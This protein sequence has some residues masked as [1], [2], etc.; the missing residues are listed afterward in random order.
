M[1][2]PTASTH[3]I[4]MQMGRDT[5]LGSIEEGNGGG[6][7]QGWKMVG[8]GYSVGGGSEGGGVGPESQQQPTTKASPTAADTHPPLLLLELLQCWN[9]LRGRESHSGQQGATDLGFR[10]TSNSPAS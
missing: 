7:G 6:G 5:K 3:I 10:K 8:G 1:A 2:A 9:Q 4:K